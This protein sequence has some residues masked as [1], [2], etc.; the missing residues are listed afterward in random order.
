MLGQ[1]ASSVSVS[2]LLS[3][4]V[5]GLPEFSPIAW[6]LIML[7][8]MAIG[9]VLLRRLLGP[10]MLA[11]PGKGLDCGF[12]FDGRS[13]MSVTGPGQELLSQAAEGR[14]PLEQLK[15]VFGDDDLERQID[16]LIGEGI[17]FSRII[18]SLDG[19]M[20]EVIGHP[21][22][23]MARIL[24]KT[25]QSYEEDQAS[26]VKELQRLRRDVAMLNG[27]LNTVP[28]LMAAIDA[29]G[30]VKW[31][32][33]GLT[34]LD[35]VG[36]KATAAMKSA[37]SER[38]CLQDASGQDRWYLLRRAPL[39]GD[40][41]AVV[42]TPIDPLIAAEQSLANFVS[43]LTETFAHL[44][45]GLA[46]FDSDGR[47]S[48]FNPAL[49]DL[50]HVDPTRL[51]AQP[52]IRAFLELLRDQRMVPEQR[53]FAAWRQTITRL[54]HGAREGTYREDWTLP[55]GRVLRV[56][57][58]PHPNGAV[59]LIFEDISSTVTL[60]RRYR[61]EI[62]LGQA[63]LDRISDAVAIFDTGGALV[64][65]NNAFDTLWSVDTMSTLE[66]PD[67]AQMTRRW[68]E[69][70]LPTPVWDRLRSY[71]T[72][73]QSRTSWQV[74]VTTRSK[75]FLQAQFSP[76]PNGS[77]L[78]VFSRAHSEAADATPDPLPDSA[79]AL[80]LE[81]IS[82]DLDIAE[83]TRRAEGAAFSIELLRT[84]MPVSGGR[85][86]VTPQALR[87]KLRDFAASRACGIEFADWDWGGNGAEARPE[88]GS[89]GS[90]TAQTATVSRTEAVLVWSLLLVV[91]DARD[92][93]DGDSQL[94]L[95]VTRREG[96]LNILAE[97]RGLQTG[98]DSL[99]FRYLE[100][101]TAHCCAD[102]SLSLEPGQLRLCCRLED[103]AQD[104]SGLSAAIPVG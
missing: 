22:G 56:I 43:T 28:G 84:L 92:H 49:A 71:V 69:A 61:D 18:S 1:S 82:E 39:S 68:T 36:P 101:L 52:S 41:E 97:Y 34:Q 94:Q 95:S 80:L 53:D 90:Q 76:L 16:T 93:A 26:T 100:R 57:G 66:A 102:P 9:G 99:A 88:A 78:T 45:T 74:E 60:E 77:T 86:G 12:L 35:E 2:G 25:V 75:L 87:D 14:E 46:I 50:T 6:G 55:S 103:T 58:R 8:L 15:A 83:P 27:L 73:D 79:R 32:N 19:R 38:I 10:R 72:S 31:R 40:S 81:L 29:E 62:E 70:C 85:G 48:L 89:R 91:L 63:A 42:A 64:F 47:L 104:A 11:A 65:A 30:Y 37:R 3:P 13:L 44:T 4:F 67:I 23:G 98:T 24:L 5:S 21:V 59:A 96:D 54:E 51:I 20:M 7:V 17:G 33:P